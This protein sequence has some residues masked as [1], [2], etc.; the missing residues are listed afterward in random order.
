M[1]SQP[2]LHTRSEFWVKTYPNLGNSQMGLARMGLAILGPGAQYCQPHLCRPHFQ[3]S[4]NPTQIAETNG[5]PKFSN[6]LIFNLYPWGPK[7]TQGVPKLKFHEIMVWT[8]V[9]KWFFTQRSNPAS[10]IVETCPKHWKYWFFQNIRNPKKD[11]KFKIFIFG[12]KSIPGP[13]GP[14]WGP[15]RGPGAP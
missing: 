8:Y 5:T 14:F 6:N 4:E 3:I 13:L 1:P 12:F 10:E 2:K 9:T 7:G 15:W 11:R